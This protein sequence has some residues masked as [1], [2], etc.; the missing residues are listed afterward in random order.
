MDGR[1]GAGAADVSTRVKLRTFEALGA[2]PLDIHKPWETSEQDFAE[3]LKALN[4]DESVAGIIVQN[5]MH[6][7]LIPFLSQIDPSKDLDAL[8]RS[9]SCPF[10]LPATS[11]AILRT[12]EPFLDGDSK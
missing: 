4:E 11:E 6:E 9:S 8:S 7:D 2:T 1:A 10:P 12:A 3:T 5:P